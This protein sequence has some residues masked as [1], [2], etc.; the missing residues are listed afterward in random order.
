MNAYVEKL[1]NNPNLVSYSCDIIGHRDYLH[2]IS[3]NKDVVEMGVRCGFSSVCFLK[4]CKT[5]VSYDIDFT[6]EAQTLKW[7][8]PSWKFNK[9]SSLEVDITECDILFIDTDH[10]YSQLLAELTKHH[11]KAKSHII[12]HDTYLDGM[13]KALNEFLEKQPEWKIEF[14]TPTNNGLTTLKRI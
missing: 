12:M 13:R 10:T 7:E 1:Y 3:K 2:T 6:E 4:G 14:D 11:A 5:L 8:C 9:Q